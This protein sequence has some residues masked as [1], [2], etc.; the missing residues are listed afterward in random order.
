MTDYAVVIVSETVNKK[1]ATTFFLI[2]NNI[3]I[4]LSVMKRNTRNQ[5]Q[6]ILSLLRYVHEIVKRVSLINKEVNR[7]I[8]QPT[9]RLIDICTGKA[10][11]K[12]CGEFSCQSS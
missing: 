8:V 6:M 11:V 1:L 2:Y 10:A 7:R 4:F 9:W 12:M 5:T 3:Y